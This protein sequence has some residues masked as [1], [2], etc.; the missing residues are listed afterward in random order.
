MLPFLLGGLGSK[1]QRAKSEEQS[2]PQSGSLEVHRQDCRVPCLDNLN[3]C[4]WM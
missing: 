1:K 2:D 3:D 4:G